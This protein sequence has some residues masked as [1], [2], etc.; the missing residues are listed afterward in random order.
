MAHDPALRA[1]AVIR[2]PVR[3]QSTTSPWILRIE[4]SERLALPAGSFET[5]RLSREPRDA[6]DTQQ[7]QFWL[8]PQLA[9]LPVRIR[10]RE[11]DG[12][13]LDQRLRASRQG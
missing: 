4:A 5:W 8:A 12:D 9:W 13:Q 6:A 7:L 2:F 3:G 11:A 1:G 10:M